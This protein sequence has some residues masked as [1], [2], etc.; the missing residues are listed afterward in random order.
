MVERI[1]ERS[2]RSRLQEK[3][4]KKA[5]IRFYQQ[6]GISMYIVLK[7]TLEKYL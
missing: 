2:V 3:H 5:T 1:N 7:V 4:T 6:V